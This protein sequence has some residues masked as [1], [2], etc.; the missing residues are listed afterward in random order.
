MDA[1]GLK[2]LEKRRF[3]LTVQNNRDALLA[4]HEERATALCVPSGLTDTEGLLGELPSATAATEE[5]AL[6]A[7]TSSEHTQQLRRRS[8]LRIT[9]ADV[10]RPPWGVNAAGGSNCDE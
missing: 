3:L 7:Q 6:S 4:E 9:G 8:R 10:G 5:T 2:K 1:L